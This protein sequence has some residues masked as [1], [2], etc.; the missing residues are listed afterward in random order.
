MNYKVFGFVSLENSRRDSKIHHCNTR[1]Y[2]INSRRDIHGIATWDTPRE[3]GAINFQYRSA[4]ASTECHLELRDNSGVGK[5]RQAAEGRTEPVNRS[6]HTE[7]CA[8]IVKECLTA[9]LSS[10]IHTQ[11]V[12]F[13]WPGKG[14]FCPLTQIPRNRKKQRRTV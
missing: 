6:Y 2:I 11:E 5:T 14:P 10:D 9:P 8:W 13:T 3:N 1:H 4:D 12:I 7:N